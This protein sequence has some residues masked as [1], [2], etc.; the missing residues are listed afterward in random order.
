MVTILVMLLR[1][2]EFVTRIGKYHVPIVKPKFPT[3][4]TFAGGQHGRR[5]GG[6]YLF[7]TVVLKRK[8]RWCNRKRWWL[9]ARARAILCPGERFNRMRI[10]ARAAK[11]SEDR[12]AY[13][14]LY[15]RML[16]RGRNIKYVRPSTPCEDGRVARRTTAIRWLCFSPQ[17]VESLKQMCRRQRLP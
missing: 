13:R 6:E 10:E 1:M 8:I 12:Q 15:D 2:T 4:G 16:G 17:S 5:E 14:D 3:I 7:W 11:S 9:T